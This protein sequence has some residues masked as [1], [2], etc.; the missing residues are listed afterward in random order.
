MCRE[1]VP[2]MRER[3]W[4]RIVNVLSLS[5]RQPEDNLALSTVARTALAAYTKV[6]SDEV[7]PDGITVNSVLPSSV[8]TDRLRAVAEMQAR[9]RGHDPARGLEERIGLIPVG[10]VARPDEIAD[11]ICYL[12]SDRAGFIAGLN[13]PFD[14]GRLRSTL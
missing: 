9:F 8:D 3:R 1:V 11:F 12:A 5:I 7:A 2:I 10:R 14:G 6:L 4:G 13:L